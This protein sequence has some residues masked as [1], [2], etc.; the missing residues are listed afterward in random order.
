[1]VT[2]TVD[3]Y[4]SVV[5]Y[6][7]V[8]LDPEVVAATAATAAAVEAVEELV[9]SSTELVELTELTELVA[10]VSEVAAMVA[11]SLLSKFKAFP[12]IGKALTAE[13]TSNAAGIMFSIILKECRT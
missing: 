10:E 3:P 9:V 5:R 13:A 6:V 8:T 4:T 7:L 12:P 2:V 1:M 11:L